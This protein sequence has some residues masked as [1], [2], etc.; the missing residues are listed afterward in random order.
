MFHTAAT[1]PDTREAEEQQVI[2][3]AWTRCI[4]KAWFQLSHL[5][6]AI[7]A[8]CVGL[9]LRSQQCAWAHRHLIWAQTGPTHNQP[10]WVRCTASVNNS[11]KQ[12]SILLPYGLTGEHFHVISLER[13]ASPGSQT[14]FFGA[15]IWSPT[16][17]VTLTV[18]T[19]IKLNKINLATAWKL[20]NSFSSRE[21]A[22]SSNLFAIIGLPP[23]SLC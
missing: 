22:L 4:C 8:V 14:R 5:M 2:G 19:R 18:H 20:L 11:S 15:W 3:K 1:W 16:V 23:G 12:P 17:T 9:I 7:T 10:H 6:W 21:Q 13:T